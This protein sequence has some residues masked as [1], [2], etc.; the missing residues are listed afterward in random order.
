MLAEADLF[1]E[2]GVHSF[3]VSITGIRPVYVPPSIVNY[4]ILKCPNQKGPPSST[5]SIPSCS[6]GITEAPGSC[7]PVVPVLSEGLGYKPRASDSRPSILSTTQ[8]S[9]KLWGKKLGLPVQKNFLILRTIQKVVPKMEPKYDPQKTS[10]PALG[11]SKQS[12]GATIQKYGRHKS[13]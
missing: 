9:R 5:P 2:R 1:L 11:T 12:P 10:F 7:L 13:G 6:R 4:I 3:T 8:I